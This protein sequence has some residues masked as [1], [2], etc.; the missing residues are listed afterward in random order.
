M[1]TVF[2]IAEVARVVDCEHKTAPAVPSEE[3]YGFAIGTPALRTDRVNFSEAKPVSKETYQRWSKRTELQ[4]GDIIIAREAPVGGLGW[5]DG[6]RKVCLGQRTVC[7]R[8]NQQIVDSKFLFYKLHDPDVQQQISKMSSGSTVDH[9]NVSDI[10]ELTLNNILGIPEQIQAIKYLEAI[11]ECIDINLEIISK[12]ETLSRLIY[13]FWFLQ[14]E[15]PDKNGKPYKSS[16]GPMIW[17]DELQKEIPQGWEI[18]ELSALLNENAISFVQPD[19]P[20]DIN[21]IDLSVMPSGSFVLDESN[22]SDNFSSNL[23]ELRK[24]DLLFGAIRPYLR[25]AGYS[26]IDGLVTGTVH[27]FSPVD[28]FDFNFSLL[29]LVHDSVSKFAIANSKGTK[30]PVIAK[31][32]LL[33]YKVAYDKETSKIFQNFLDFRETVSSK[34]LQNLELRKLRDYLLPLLVNGIIEV[35]AG[36]IGKA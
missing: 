5:V 8:A 10:K 20:A 4:A 32:D 1:G 23:F 2:K 15:F 33:T 7:V 18:K 19:L 31:R 16:G 24:N 21:V 9:I 14:F 17:S 35:S 12:I 3:A 27:S 26:P 36:G 34:V 25:K 22:S 30:M 13:D 28:S 6:N 11:D 29:T